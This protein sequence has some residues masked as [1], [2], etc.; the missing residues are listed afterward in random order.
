MKTFWPVLIVSPDLQI[1]RYIASVLESWGMESLCAST[2]RQA[3]GIL[4][5]RAIPLVFSEDQLQDGDFQDVV[6]AAKFNHPATRVVVASRRPSDDLRYIRSMPE[7]A[8][9]DV[10][11]YPGYVHD[12]QLA[13]ARALRKTASVTNAA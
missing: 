4:M 2:V 5:Q 10:I 9:T 6:H 7:L 3:R 11:P 12:V 1:R 13:I 8:E